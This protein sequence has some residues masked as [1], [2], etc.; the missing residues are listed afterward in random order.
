VVAQGDLLSVVL[1]RMLKPVG[2]ADDLVRVRGSDDAVISVAIP[3][4]C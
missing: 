3:H 2:N 4:G 1:A